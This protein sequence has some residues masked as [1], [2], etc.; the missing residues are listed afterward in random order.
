MD[1]NLQ[2]I[3]DDQK[4]VN[5]NGSLTKFKATDTTAFVIHAISKLLLTPAA[6]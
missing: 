3:G 4:D 2:R 1:V 5:C 6:F